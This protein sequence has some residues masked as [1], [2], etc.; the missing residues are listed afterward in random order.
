MKEENLPNNRLK[1]VTFENAPGTKHH[2]NTTQQI[3]LLN[4]MKTTQ[5]PSKLKQMAGLKSVAEVYRTL[6]KM[7]LRKEYHRALSRHGIDFSFIVEG[8]KAECLGAEK[9]SD[10]LNG[11]KIL[12]KSLGMET[13]DENATSGG[14]SWEDAIK[15][16]VNESEEKGEDVDEDGDYEVIAPAVPDSVRQIKKA[17]SE[18][19]NGL[20]D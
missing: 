1:P 9:S 17:E 8:I 10:R 6:D 15:K 5:D 19:K 2:Q 20:Y 13:Y 16:V 11:Y 7:A 14:G 12:L 3:L 4:A 18:M